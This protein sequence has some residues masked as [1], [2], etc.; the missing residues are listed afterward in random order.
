MSLIDEL[1]EGDDILC[2]LFTSSSII[3]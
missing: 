3:D 2:V 1:N